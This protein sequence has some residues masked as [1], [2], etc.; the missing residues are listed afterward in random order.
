[1]AGIAS[2][3]R[4][5]LQV[6][7]TSWRLNPPS[8]Y[9]P[10]FMPDPLLGFPLQSL[11]PPAQP[12]TVS[13]TAPLMPLGIHRFPFDR[14]LP[15]YFP[16]QG[17][18]SKSKGSLQARVHTPSSG[19]SSTRE[20]ATHL[21]GLDQHEHIA[22]LSLRPLQGFLLCSKRHDLH[23]ISPPAVYK[24]VQALPRPTTGS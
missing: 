5:H 21:G 6:F 1:M 13:D 20:S 19:F 7:S 3:N 17:L 4:L 11:T 22:L 9:W 24:K 10:F 15:S 8:V 23:R 2:P 12:Y 14:T 16:V 18:S